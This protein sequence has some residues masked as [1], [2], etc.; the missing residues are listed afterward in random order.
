MAD[1]AEKHIVAWKVIRNCNPGWHHRFVFPL[2]MHINIC[3][4]SGNELNTPTEAEH[5]QLFHVIKDASGCQIK[6]M[7]KASGLNELQL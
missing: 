1:E 6:Y 5:G 4:N 7:G 2:D 3:D